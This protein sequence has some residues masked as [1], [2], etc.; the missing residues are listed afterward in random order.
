ME[1]LAHSC[2]T[3]RIGQTNWRHRWKLIVGLV[4]PMGLA[5]HPALRDVGGFRCR[6]IKVSAFRVVF[7]KC[8]IHPKSKKV[9]QIERYR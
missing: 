2:S 7:F 4:R 6:N 8:K 5:A 1:T 3:L 9:F